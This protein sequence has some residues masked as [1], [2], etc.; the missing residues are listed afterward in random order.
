M[1]FL[2]GMIVGAAALF[3]VNDIKNDITSVSDSSDDCIDELAKRAD[4]HLND[5]K[6][7]KS[8]ITEIS[9][10]AQEADH[11]INNKIKELVN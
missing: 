1:E 4:G 9:D 7:A 8:Q 6:N 11:D 5:F 3:V 2:I 10:K